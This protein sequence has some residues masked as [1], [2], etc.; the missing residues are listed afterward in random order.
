MWGETGLGKTRNAIERL[1]GNLNDIYFKD[2]SNKWW[3]GYKGEKKVL[4]DELPFQASE[5]MLDK[6]KYWVNG[7]PTLVETKGGEVWL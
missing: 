3:S 4:I 2:S 1:G 7:I 6:L 5:W